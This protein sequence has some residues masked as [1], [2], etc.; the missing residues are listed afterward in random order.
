MSSGL[1]IGTGHLDFGTPGHLDFWP[2]TCPH[3]YGKANGAPT[4][5]S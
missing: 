1:V 2:H 3:Q 4:K 5:V